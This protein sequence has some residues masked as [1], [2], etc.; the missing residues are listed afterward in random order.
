MRAETIGFKVP[1]TNACDINPL[2][3]PGAV[4]L[5]TASSRASCHTFFSQ[6][7][8]VQYI[9]RVSSLSR[10]L[11]LCVPDGAHRQMKEKLARRRRRTG[12]KS[13]DGTL[14]ETRPPAP[15]AVSSPK[16]A[17]PL[18]SE[19]KELAPLGPLGALGDFKPDPEEGCPCR[20]P[21][22]AEADSYDIFTMTPQFDIYTPRDDT[23]ANRPLRSKRRHL[24][25]RKVRLHIYDVS[26]DP[27]IQRV[28][29]VFANKDA[30]IKL[31]G[32]FHAGVEISKLEWAFGSGC[33]HESPT[34]VRCH[35]PK[36]NIQHSYRQTVYLGRSQCSRE[37]VA[38]ILAEI[39]EEY[40]AESYDLLR[41]NCCH[42]ADDLCRRLGVRSP[43]FW[44]LRL[45]CVGAA[46]DEILPEN[47]RDLLPW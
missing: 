26:R 24:K 43:P 28:N 4:A 23:A 21:C 14:T 40:S 12:L 2:L 38:R 11:M 36:Q 8:R 27:N 29:F 39:A 1:P 45:A 30:P 44:L 16:P 13:A 22:P 34:G 33:L 46:V 15:A 31:G 9:A 3:K 20:A 35:Q 10:N 42:F 41:K 7:A 25:G 19:R 18:S 5:C 32:L 6:T 47:V 37:E 17:E